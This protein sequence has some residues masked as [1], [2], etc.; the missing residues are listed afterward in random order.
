MFLINNNVLTIY[1]AEIQLRKLYLC[2]IISGIII[3]KKIT[4][5]ILKTNSMEKQKDIMGWTN[6]QCELWSRSSST[7][8]RKR[9]NIQNSKKITKPLKHMYVF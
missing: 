8:E 1:H 9:E 4:K 6:G 5:K 7:K 2:H 3:R